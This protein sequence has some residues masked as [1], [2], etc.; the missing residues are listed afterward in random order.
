MDY[1]PSS[2]P[3]VQFHNRNPSV[4]DNI[5]ICQSYTIGCHHVSKSYVYKNYDNFMLAVS[6]KLEKALKK[7]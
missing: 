6:L 5:V 4:T 3:A 1:F 7:C 2:I